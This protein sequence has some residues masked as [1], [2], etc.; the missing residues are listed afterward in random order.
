[1]S[2]LLYYSQSQNMTT[3]SP[4]RVTLCIQSLR[5]SGKR[6]GLSGIIY[7]TISIIVC[8]ACTLLMGFLIFAEQFGCSVVQRVGLGFPDSAGLEVP[9]IEWQ[10]SDSCAAASIAKND[11]ALMLRFHP[12]SHHLA[13]Y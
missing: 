2:I 11:K 5:D 9:T 10:C 3:R 12:S 6:T 7:L 13:A 8:R 1:M 4:G